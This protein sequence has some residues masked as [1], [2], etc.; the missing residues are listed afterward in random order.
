MRV[1]VTMLSVLILAGGA[2]AAEDSL[3][4]PGKSVGRITKA[5]TVEELRQL[6]GKKNVTMEELPLGEG[7]TANGAVVYGTNPRQ[8][9]QVAWN[10]ADATRCV[11]WVRVSG[12][13]SDWHTSEGITLG[14]SLT[15]LEKLNEH[16]FK[17]YGFAWDYGGTV[18]GW[19]GGKLERALKARGNASFLEERRK[20]S[21]KTCV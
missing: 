16:P 2:W 1:C 6:F 20:K 18:A 13:A 11:Q 15:E 3:I 5:T 17:L 14:T 8:K 19:Q 10:D 12:K 7:E 21:G 4:V 9:L